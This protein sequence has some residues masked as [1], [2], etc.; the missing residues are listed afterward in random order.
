MH[1]HE[2]KALTNLNLTT[3]KNRDLW[4]TSLHV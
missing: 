3:I 1:Y 2:A 4:R